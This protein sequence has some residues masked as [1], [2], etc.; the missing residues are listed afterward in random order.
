MSVEIPNHVIKALLAVR[1]SGKV[2]MFDRRGV[3]LQATRLG[4]NKA[5]AWLHYH[6]ANFAEAL[7]ALGKAV[8]EDDDAGHHSPE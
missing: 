8:G 1:E 5:G 2:N 7:D 6:R 4:H 3:I